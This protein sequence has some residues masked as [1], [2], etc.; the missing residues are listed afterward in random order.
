MNGVIGVYVLVMA[1]PLNSIRNLSST[2]LLVFSK[3]GKGD[4]HKYND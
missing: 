3:N 4:K 2:Q 1:N